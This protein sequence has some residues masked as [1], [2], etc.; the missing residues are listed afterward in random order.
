MTEVLTLKAVLLF[1]CLNYSFVYFPS[2]PS[3]LAF[4]FLSFEGAM[5]W[6]SHNSSYGLA[7]NRRMPDRLVAN[8][9]TVYAQSLRGF[10][11]LCALSSLAT[12]GHI[13]SLSPVTSVTSG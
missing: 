5:S 2:K 13:T 9:R 4:C 11:C 3:L 1:Y 12:T 10:V 6:G 7:R 8:A